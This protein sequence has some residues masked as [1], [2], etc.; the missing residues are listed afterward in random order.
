MN[1]I[2]RGDASRLQEQAP[3]RANDNAAD[4]PRYTKEVPEMGIEGQKRTALEMVRMIVSDIE[5]GVAERDRQ[6]E[7][8]DLEREQLALRFNDAIESKRQLLASVRDRHGMARSAVRRF[9]LATRERYAWDLLPP[10]FLYSLFKK[11][12]EAE[13]AHPNELLLQSVHE[14]EL[15]QIRRGVHTRDGFRYRF[16]LELADLIRELDDG[17]WDVDS[18]WLGERVGDRMSV[19]EQ[20]AEHAGHFWTKPIDP[21]KRYKGAVFRVGSTGEGTAAPV[22]NELVPSE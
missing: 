1:E 21:A 4:G 20:S 3:E 6:L 19:R 16:A 5:N 12:G 8:L 2:S 17:V 14:W 22:E 15:A 7:R 11:W 13:A 9:W 18:L 10:A